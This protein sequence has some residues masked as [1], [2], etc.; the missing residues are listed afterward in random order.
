MRV[1]KYLNLVEQLPAVGAVF[2]ALRASARATKFALEHEIA[3]RKWVWSVRA[4][5]SVSITRHE[6]CVAII[7]S[8]NAKRTRNLE[9][10]VR[11]FLHCNF[12]SKMIVSNHNP[13]LRVQDWVQ[14]NDS[15]LVLINQPA[16]RGHGYAFEL[17]RAESCDYFIVLDDDF[18]IAPKQIATLFEHL[19]DEPQIPHGLAGIL[20][21]K[22]FSSIESEVDCLFHVFA[23]TRA[24]ALAY[25]DYA[26]R[27]AQLGEVRLNEIE[28]FA[29]DIVYSR[30]G[31]TKAKIHAVG[32]L[33]RCKTSAQA[34]IAFHMSPGFWE[35][36]NRVTTEL[37]KLLVHARAYQVQAQK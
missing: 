14:T 11:S 6:K 19:L 34:D 36:R 7:P 23:G 3:F 5:P 20:G 10:L 1:S 32:A 4:A 27:L 2:P 25:L 31:P 28:Y 17:A 21:S 24:H 9:P 22:L 33:L 8:Y 29:D 13:A 15:R 30:V 16:R 35:P 12:I 26:E 18:L 37:E